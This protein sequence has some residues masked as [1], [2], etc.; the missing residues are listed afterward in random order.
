MLSRQ[1]GTSVAVLRETYVHID[2]SDADWAHL[3]DFGAARP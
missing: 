3:N 1:V 2:I